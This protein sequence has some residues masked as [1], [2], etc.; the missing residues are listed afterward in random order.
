MFDPSK[1]H[2]CVSFLESLRTTDVRPLKNACVC[3][4]SREFTH[5]RCSSPQK[6]TCVFNFSDSLYTT[7]IWPL[8]TARVCSISQTVYTLQ[9]FDPSKNACDGSHDV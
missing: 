9:M 7:Y 5:Y 1:M 2:V 6:C 8:K 3:F 4:I